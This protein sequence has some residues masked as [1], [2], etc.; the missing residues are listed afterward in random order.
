MGPF[1][2]QVA[3]ISGGLGDIGYAIGQELGGLGARIAIGDLLEED[4]CDVGERLAE[5]RSKQIEVR[6]SKVD[7]SREDEVA[8]WLERT[9]EQLGTPTLI[10]PNAGIVTVRLGLE[11]GMEQ[12]QHELDVNVK[13]AFCLAQLGARQLKRERR[14]GKIVFIGSWAG[15][16]AHIQSPAYCASKAAVRSL[17]RCLARELAPDGIL[18]NEVAPGAV[19]AG[20]V[21]KIFTRNPGMREEAVKNIPVG[22][23]IQAEEVA[24]QVAHLCHPRNR[25]MTGSVVVVDGGLSLTDAY[26]S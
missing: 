17:C 22:S 6:Y 26:T 18:V 11:I 3:I 16:S 4:H 10:I 1:H 20:L 13:G 19:D 7:V 21:K 15:H 9:T 24:W 23:F 8:R 14:A 2:T 25:N 12:L 5:L